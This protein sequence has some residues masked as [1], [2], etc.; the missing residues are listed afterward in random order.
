[1][2][3]SIAG[4]AGA[5]VAG[6]LLATLEASDNVT[7]LLAAC[8]AIAP[9]DDA[10]HALTALPNLLVA[11][12]LGHNSEAARLWFAE[13]WHILRPALL[14]RPALAPRIWNT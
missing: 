5:S 9:S 4:W 7:S 8:R 13:L 3:A 2:L 6:T 10:E 1:M 11:R 12:Y 14:G